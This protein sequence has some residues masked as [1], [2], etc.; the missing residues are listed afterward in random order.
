[1]ASPSAGQ[2]SLYQSR[3]LTTKSHGISALIS[4]KP[5][6]TT[7]AR[8]THFGVLDGKRNEIRRSKEHQGVK[9]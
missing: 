8:A 5:A 9:E 3:G 4:K 7:P 1:F 6:G 2:D